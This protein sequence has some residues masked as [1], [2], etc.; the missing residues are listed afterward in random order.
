MLLTMNI[1]LSMLFMFMNHPLSLGMVLLLQTAI[2]SMISGQFCL[3]YWFSYI[4]FLILVGGML[5]LFIYMTSIA[6]NEKF[7]L[8]I[9]LL[10]FLTISIFISFLVSLSNHYMSDSYTK[11][12]L[13]L[14]E[15]FHLNFS[16]I[17]FISFPMNLILLFMIIYLFLAL[18]AIVKIIDRKQGPLR[19]KY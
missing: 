4:L 14:I 7:N 15:N 9:E 6:S 3:N 10:L 18:I 19:P 17:K 12:E 2:I 13:T 16:M 8:K 11:N 5:I 1:A